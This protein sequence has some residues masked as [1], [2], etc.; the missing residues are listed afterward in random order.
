MFKRV[1]ITNFLCLKNVDVE[2]EP[3]TIF[4]GPNSSG[5]SALFKALVV[6][7]R[8]LW[9]PV[10]GGKTGPFQLES[11]ITLDEIVWNRDSGLPIT[12][13]VWFDDSQQVA[14]DYYIELRRS[15]A[16]WNVARE[17]FPFQGQMLDS[18]QGF[19]FETAEAPPRNRKVWAGPFIAPL[20]YLT[21]RFLGD[22]K[23]GPYLRPIQDLRTRLGQARR[24]RPSASDIASFVKT[25]AEQ[26]ARP[27][28]DESGRR[29]PHA[30]QWV[31]NTDRQM[32]EGIEKDLTA[33]HSHVL[34]MSFERD[35]RGTGL[36]YTTIRG[37]GRTPANLESDGVL[38]STFLLWRLH[39]APENM[40]LCWEEPENGVHLAELRHRYELLKQFA[41]QGPGGRNLQ[42]LVATHSRDFLNAI[43]RSNTLQE[44]RVVE[45]DP[46]SGTK[47]IPLAHYREINQLLGEFNG[48]MGDLWWSDRLR[49]APRQ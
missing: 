42:I 40:K 19:T 36:V 46:T 2:L 14:P 37:G 7:S 32:F 44:V 26:D 17:R 49:G 25:G 45:F 3:L 39:T 6:L 9:Y 28:V 23:A 10:S 43:G 33:L 48:Q 27:E 21:Q 31:L 38:L 12:F 8:L 41:T 16:G 30:L 35:Y 22:G 4:A 29:L 24:Y 47:I 18:G 11:G 15:Y 13:E 20:A 34:G 1:R 5:K